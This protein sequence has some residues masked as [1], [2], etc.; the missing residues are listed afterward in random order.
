MTV[1]LAQG[2][3]GVG[4]MWG[5]EM[6]REYL[7]KAGFSSVQKN[8]LVHDIQNNWYVVRK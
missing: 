4:A 2:G 5:E 3:E 8:E 1:S 6:T 7:K